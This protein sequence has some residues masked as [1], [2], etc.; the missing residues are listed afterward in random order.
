MEKRL[1][2][3]C[4]WSLGLIGVLPVLYGV[5]VK[6]TTWFGGFAVDNTFL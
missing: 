5:I 6:F 4:G 2:V 1:G 3:E